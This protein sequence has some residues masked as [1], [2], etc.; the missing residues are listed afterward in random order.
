MKIFICHGPL[1]YGIGAT[2]RAAYTNYA[3]KVKDSG[4]SPAPRESC[5]FFKGK[6]VVGPCCKCPTSPC[7]CG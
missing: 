4:N 6:A 3:Q 2:K 1:Y 7:R 5:M